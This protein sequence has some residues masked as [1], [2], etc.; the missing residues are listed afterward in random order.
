MCHRLEIVFISPQISTQGRLST[1]LEQTHVS[2]HLWS[3]SPARS[4]CSAKV[5]CLEAL[6]AWIVGGLARWP[7]GRRELR[8]GSQAP[9]V[10]G[11]ASARPARSGGP[12]PGPEGRCAAAEL[13]AGGRQQR[14][15]RLADLSP[16]KC[17]GP[18]CKARRQQSGPHW[19]H[20]HY[21]E[22]WPCSSR[23][24][25][26]TSPSLSIT[27]VALRSGIR[28]IQTTFIPFS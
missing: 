8:R 25:R 2:L 7:R 27:H 23:Y 3:R 11:A 4:R 13:S 17:W 5:C 9:A 14:K 10:L 1:T 24:L 15:C 28:H 26:D 18:D 12:R 20:C 21:P 6:G 19:G 16:P 22:R